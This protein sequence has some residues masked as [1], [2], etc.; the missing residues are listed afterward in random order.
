MDTASDGTASVNRTSAACPYGYAVEI[1]C[2][3]RIKIS[4][5]VELRIDVDSVPDH[6]G[7]L[8]GRSSKR[9]RRHHPQAIFLEINY[10]IVIQQ[11]GKRSLVFVD[12]GIGQF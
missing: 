11:R 6:G 5:S 12:D 10:G 8:G 3:N 4:L 9:R 1:P 7:L 2:G